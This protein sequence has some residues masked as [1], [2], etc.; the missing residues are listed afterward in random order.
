MI[1]IKIKYRLC[2]NISHYRT[3]F[4]LF[5][6]FLFFFSNFFCTFPTPDAV[7]AASVRVC[8]CVGEPM[9]KY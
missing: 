1:I 2:L 3:D 5:F 9:L 6:S 4:I 7:W 8:V